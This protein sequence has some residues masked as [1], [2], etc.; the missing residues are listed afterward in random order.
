MI[1]A[2]DHDGARQAFVAAGKSLSPDVVHF[3]GLFG[4][5]CS[6]ASKL[7]VSEYLFDHLFCMLT[8]LIIITIRISV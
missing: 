5:K 1:G 3:E 7:G 2:A 8:A 4:N 6:E